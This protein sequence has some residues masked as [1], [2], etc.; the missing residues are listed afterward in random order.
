MNGTLRDFLDQQEDSRFL[1][2]VHE[3]GEGCAV[4][5]EDFSRLTATGREDFA[6]LLNAKVKEVRADIYGMEIVISGAEPE[7]LMRFNEAHDAFM[8][9]EWAMGDMTP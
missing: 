7:E 5:A 4:P 1:F 8:E 9:A 2:V 6:A 3:T